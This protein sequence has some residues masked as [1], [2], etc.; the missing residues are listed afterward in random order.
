MVVKAAIISWLAHV[1][2]AQYHFIENT[3]KYAKREKK[4]PTTFIVE[5]K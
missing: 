1:N 3:N 5:A 2:E 4:N